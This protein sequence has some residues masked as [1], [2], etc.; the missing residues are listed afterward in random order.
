LKKHL[1]ISDRPLYF[2]PSERAEDCCSERA[3][4][5]LDTRDL[6]VFG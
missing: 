4:R 1:N 2:F 5:D 3:V 6:I